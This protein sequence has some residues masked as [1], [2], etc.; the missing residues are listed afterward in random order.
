MRKTVLFLAS[1]TLNQ[2]LRP[3]LISATQRSGKNARS[4]LATMSSLV[5][6]LAPPWPLFAIYDGGAPY[7][8]I[9]PASVA[10]VTA[11]GG[12]SD[13]QHN[14]SQCDRH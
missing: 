2:I 1:T 3:C 6:I 14:R 9:V 7:A 4:I 13:E 12:R 5:S 10:Q 11:R 8:G